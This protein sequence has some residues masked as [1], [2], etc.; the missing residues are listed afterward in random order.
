MGGT[1]FSSGVTVA[2]VDTFDSTVE[3]WI[4]GGSSGTPPEW[5]SSGGPAGSAYM[6]NDSPGQSPGRNMQ[7]WNTTQWQGDY[8]GAG[9]SSISL[10][11]NNLTE[12]GGESLHLRIAF[13]GEG[14]W[15][16]S[17]PVELSPQSGWTQLTF[18]IGLADLVHA[19]EGSE[20]YEETM[21]EVTR[22]QIISLGPNAAFDIGSGSGLRGEAIL[23]S[24]GID[25]I[26]AI[27]VP[28]PESLFFLSI[29]TL[30]GFRRSRMR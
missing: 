15:F 5:R 22:F 23:A 20:E 24:L 16:T 8:T 1:M 9:V 10:D 30:I 18:N 3:E 27:G 13:N 2:Q 29:G 21:S 28:E 4:E 19:G 14:G 25:N 12:A 26:Q 11:A 7:M 6:H 17:Q